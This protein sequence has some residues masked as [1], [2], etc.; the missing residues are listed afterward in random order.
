[1]LDKVTKDSNTDSSKNCLL[2]LL[3]NLMGH[4]NVS[5]FWCGEFCLEILSFVN[6]LIF[7]LPDSL[8]FFL[9]VEA[10]REL[11]TE[12]KIQGYLQNQFFFFLVGNDYSVEGMFFWTIRNSQVSPNN[13]FE[14]QKGIIFSWGCIRVQWVRSTETPTS[15][16][17]VAKFKTQL[18]HALRTC[19]REK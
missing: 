10:V 7:F 2:K 6:W 14:E 13:A 5:F 17:D 11:R 18:A 1:M 12:R 16:R 15:R 9:S 4:V 19:S 3:K 8:V